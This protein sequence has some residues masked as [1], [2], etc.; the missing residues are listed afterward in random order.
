VLPWELTPKGSFWRLPWFQRRV[1][2]RAA[3]PHL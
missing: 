2:H 1:A 3:S